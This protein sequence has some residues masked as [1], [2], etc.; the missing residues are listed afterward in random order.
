M[1]EAKFATDVGSRN[2]TCS[3][4]FTDLP[5]QLSFKAIGLWRCHMT[6]YFL[7]SQ[8]P[9]ACTKRTV[10]RFNDA[11]LYPGSCLQLGMQFLANKKKIHGLLLTYYILSEALLQACCSR[12]AVNDRSRA[13]F[14]RLA[15][16][17]RSPPSVVVVACN[18][19]SARQLLFAGDALLVPETKNE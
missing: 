9:A 18:E 15:A 6:Q 1:D 17:R 14:V 13:R 8:Y 19:P 7:Q 12:A 11:N 10:N 2:M 4:S 3:T 16:C 5:P